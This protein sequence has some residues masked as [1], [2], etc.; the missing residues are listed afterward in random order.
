MVEQGLRA[1]VIDV[2]R[3]EIAALR[4]KGRKAAYDAAMNDPAILHDCFALLRARPEL[5]ASVVVDEAGQPAA[6][7]DIVLRCGATLGQCK[8]MV[9][10]AA[11]RRHFHRKLGGFR[12]IAIPSRK[13]R[14]LLS[15]LSLGLL[16][17]QPPPAT[18]RVPARGEILYRAFREYLR[19]DWQARLL[20][21]YSEFSPEEA[22]RLGPTILEMREPWELR[23]LTG[24]DGQQMRAEGGRPIFLDS[25]LRLMQANNDSIDAEILWTVSQ[26][27]ELSRLIPNADQGRM[28]KVVSLV[29]AT[30]K[31]AISQLLPLLGADMRLFVTFLFVAF[32]RLG[33]G[34]FRKCF[35]EGGENQWMAKV[36][37]DRLADGGPLPSP[38]VEEMEAAFGAVFDRA[39]GLP[40]GDRRTVLQPATS[41]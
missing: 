26:Q 7:D 12:K 8:S 23:A 38:S 5:F 41:G 16:G 20:T 35:M 32:A 33:E 31:F 34:E 9:V 3:V 17:H 2:L 15:V 19:F 6:A 36:L 30:S 21:H 22:K 18:R 4:G 13:P 11:G 14:S 28:R 24:K 29:A 39:A 1:G 27:M 25:A 40:A 10:R 37:I